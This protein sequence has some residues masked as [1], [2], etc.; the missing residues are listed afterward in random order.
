MEYATGRA[1]T[2]VAL[3]S[4]IFASQED[5]SSWQ[6]KTFE[7]ELSLYSIIQSC[8]DTFVLQPVGFH[9][10]A[11]QTPPV[12][13]WEDLDSQHRTLS[14]LPSLVLAQRAS[15]EG[16][17][18]EKERGGEEEGG[19]GGGRR[20]IR[21]EEGSYNY[22]VK[23]VKHNVLSRRTVFEKRYMTKCSN[24]TLQKNEHPKTL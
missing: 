23:A 5:Q 7:I 21:S 16:C 20:K 1:R 6:T 11:G 24:Y 19:G 18:E 2:G 22:N 10:S 14:P 3:T 15:L 13:K 8:V 12:C 17:R 4:K 9:I